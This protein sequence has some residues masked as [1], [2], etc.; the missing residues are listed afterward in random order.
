MQHPAHA[1]DGVAA[2]ARATAV[3]RAAAR[4][5]FDPRE[6]FVSDRHL[7]IGRFGH[8]GAISRP[9]PDERIGADAGVFLVD[10]RGHDQPPSRQA[11]FRNH[12]RRVNHGG[13]AAL[14]VLGSASVEAARS[15][16]GR[17]R[18]LHALDADGIHVAAEHQGSSGSTPFEHP[19]DIGTPWRDFFYLH[20]EPDAPQVRRNRRRDLRFARR[21]RDKGRVHRIDGHEIAQ[22]EEG[23]IEH[24]R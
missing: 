7:Q 8:D 6:P 2:V 17:E 10:D 24:S 4:L 16:L 12:P 14:H 1:Q 19:D 3:R 20:I 13:D 15:H 5:D 11:A 21:T 23:G 18:R 22:K 9:V